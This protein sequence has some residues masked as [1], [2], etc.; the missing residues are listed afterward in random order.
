MSKIKFFT[1]SFCLVAKIAAASSCFPPEELVI[2]ENSSQ[3]Y[4]S[5]SSGELSTTKAGCYY[6]VTNK[7]GQRIVN[8][9]DTAIEEFHQFYFAAQ[10]N[11][12]NLC[13]KN[14]VRIIDSFTNYPIML[15]ARAAAS[16]YRPEMIRTKASPHYFGPITYH[17]YL[18]N[19]KIEISYELFIYLNSLLDKAKIHHKAIQL[20][21]TI[22]KGTKPKDISLVDRNDKSTADLHLAEALRKITQQSKQILQLEAKIKTLE[23]DLCIARNEATVENESPQGAAAAK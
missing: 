12:N 6:V 5:L 13:I 21:G 18:Q 11:N 16:V 2:P 3:F 17:L 8:V 20:V 1:L 19:N 15:E 10:L 14:G 23:E 9:K 7:K 4:A 22:D